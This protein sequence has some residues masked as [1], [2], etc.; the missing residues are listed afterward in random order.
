LILS[1]AEFLD[2]GVIVD[3]R[4]ARPLAPGLMESPQQQQ[5]HAQVEHPIT[6]PSFYPSARAAV[7]FL[8]NLM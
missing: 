2:H 5:L 8:V 3:S 4:A 1:V 7:K 6:M